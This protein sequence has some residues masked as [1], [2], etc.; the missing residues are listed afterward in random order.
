[1][2][3]ACGG[4]SLA[5]NGVHFEHGSL[6]LLL[7]SFVGRGGAAPTLGTT[8][9]AT[10]HASHQRL[11][12]APE[13]HVEDVVREKVDRGARDDEKVAKLAHDRVTSALLRCRRRRR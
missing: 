10:A 2:I 6:L 4:A 12:L 1:M 8:A 9:A 5:L 13:A 11:E 7:L 3:V